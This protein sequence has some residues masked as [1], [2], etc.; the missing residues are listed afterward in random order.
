MEVIYLG[1]SSFKIKGKTS[2]V[3]VD[4]YDAKVSKF[5]KDIDANI[6]IV[7]HKH[8]DHDAVNQV[9]GKPFVIDGPGEYEVGGVSVIGVH[10]FHDDKAGA[11]RGDNT[12]YVIEFEGMRL[13]FLGDLGHKLTQEQLDEIGSIDV[14][15]VP[16]GG[17]YTIDAKVATEVVKQLDPWVVIP[18]HYA[19]LT[20]DP[21]LNSKLAPVDNF[22][23]EMGKP[24]VVAIPKFVI[25]ADRMPTEMQV[26]VL[27]RK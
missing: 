14:A 6:V 3:V 20:I 23:K 22:L 25:S 1:H 11:E 21:E 18:M 15:F 27:E 8:A 13:C 12:A 4:P 26:V 19:S 5:P 10:T 17:T 16:V 7:S 2:S 9:L 24:D